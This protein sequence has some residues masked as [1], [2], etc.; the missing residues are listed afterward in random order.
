MR[1]Q[2]GRA[3]DRDAADRFALAIQVRRA[4]PEIG[5]QPHRIL[6]TEKPAVPSVPK[7]DAN[8]GPRGLPVP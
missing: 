4:V 5:P 1:L 3:H 2:P 7:R 6:L 8:D